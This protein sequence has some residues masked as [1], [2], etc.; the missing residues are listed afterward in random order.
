MESKKV[1]AFGAFD[2]L[3]KGH[4]FFLK[5][6]KALGDFLLVVVARDISIR[7]R[8]LREPFQ[9]EDVRLQVVAKLP[10]VDE[11]VLGNEHAN[12]YKLLGELDFDIVAM[13]YDQKPSDEE[14]RLALDERSKQRVKIVRLP[15]FEPEQFKSTYLR[16]E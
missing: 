10:F 2:P 13:G 15:A 5:S 11:A 14:V 8:K 16:S 3:H 4:E 7:A 9:P 12:Q 1:I 6:A